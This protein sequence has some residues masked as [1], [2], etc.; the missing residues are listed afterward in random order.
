MSLC[1]LKFSIVFPN[2]ELF[3]SLKKYFSKLVLA[4]VHSSVFIS[5]CGFSQASWLNLILY[6]LSLVSI[7]DPMHSIYDP[8]HNSG[9]LCVYYSFSCCADYSGIS[10]TYQFSFFGVRTTYHCVDR[11][12]L[13]CLTSTLSLYPLPLSSW[14]CSPVWILQLM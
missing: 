11:V 9:L 7:Y 14:Y 10:C 5:M 13:R 4:F 3:I 2:Q 12:S 6:V 1:F 8:I